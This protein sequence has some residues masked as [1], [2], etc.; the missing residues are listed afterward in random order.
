MTDYNFQ[1]LKDISH[2]DCNN[3]ELNK[4]INAIDANITGKTN[5]FLFHLVPICYS[6]I[7]VGG[8]ITFGYKMIM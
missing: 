5:S 1:Y 4:I 8:F 2:S 6:L 7:F 3:Y